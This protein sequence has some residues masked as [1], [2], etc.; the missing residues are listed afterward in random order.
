MVKPLSF[1]FTALLGWTCLAGPG[2]AAPAADTVTDGAVPSG[3]AEPRDSSRRD[4]EIRRSIAKYR[5]QVARMQ[6]EHG[7]YYP[8][9]SEAMLSL[10]LSLSAVNEHAEAADTFRS[11]LHISRV[12]HGL[13]NL[14]QL[15][16]LE[17]LIEENRALDNEEKLYKN[18]HYLY[19]LYKRNYGANDERI[20]PVINRVARWHLEAYRD[21]TD[22]VSYR[23]LLEARDLY[24]KAVEIIEQQYGEQDPRLINPLYELALSNYYIAVQANRLDEARMDRSY[25]V[26]TRADYY[27]EE[28]PVDR[29][30]DSYFAGKKALVRIVDIH[31]NN[32]ELPVESHAMAL[33]YLGDWQILFERPRSAMDR[34]G[35]AYSLLTENGADRA[36]IDAIF[37][38]PR[39]LPTIPLPDRR[40][41][42]QRESGTSLPESASYAIVSFDVLSN[43]RTRNIRVV[44]ASP[45]DSHRVTRTA[46]R[47]IAATRFRPRFEDGK[48]VKTTDVNMKYIIDE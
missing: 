21:N 13:H 34:Y 32:P 39:R 48:P 11:A 31:A 1:L 27:E 14:Q 24:D 28:S 29:I 47:L 15:P 46:R 2:Y 6:A 19:W 9:L 8:Q 37:G 26:S 22:V 23:H 4:E 43:G 12:N 5:K 17:L 33:T 30:L 36:T 35:E 10:G 38:S 7:A 41:A 42:K 3:N 44:E 45:A 20:L 25:E 40:R 16:Y 18:Y